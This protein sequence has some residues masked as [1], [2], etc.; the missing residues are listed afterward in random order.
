LNKLRIYCIFFFFAAKTVFP[1]EYSYKNFSVG[2]GLPQSQVV[3][4][5]QDRIGYLWFGTQSGGVARF[6]GKTFVTFNGKK[7]LP[8]N[9]VQSVY[10]DKKGNYWFATEEGLSNFD[11]IS[12]RNYGQS[13]GITRVNKVLGDKDGN[14]WFGDYNKGLFKFDGKK[15]TNYT[16][17]EG[18]ISNNIRNVYLT[19][20][21]RLLISTNAG[22]SIY[23]HNKFYNYNKS[24]GLLS[25]RTRS[26]IEDKDK[27]IW[28]AHRGGITIIDTK[29]QNRILTEKDGLPFN[30]ILNLFEDS[31]GGIW[32]CGVGGLCRFDGKKFNIVKTSDDA[33]NKR[34]YEVIEDKE[35][36]IWA[37]TDTKGA[38]RLIRTNFS[39]YSEKDGLANNNVWEICEDK[40]GIL[41]FATDRG[42]SRFDGEKFRTYNII[43]NASEDVNFCIYMDS[44]N[45]LWAGNNS[46]LARF[47]GS[48]FVL[49]PDP[50]KAFK[51]KAVLDILDDGQGN[52]WCGTFS[53]IVKYDGRKFT[54]FPLEDSL[55]V[56][57]YEVYQDHEGRI[58]IGTEYNGV[59]ICNGKQFTKFR[60]KGFEKDKKIWNITQ[61]KQNIFWFGLTENG[62]I[63]YNHETKEHIL[64]TSEDGLIDDNILSLGVDKNDMLWI[65]TNTGISRLDTRKFNNSGKIAIQNFGKEEG[66]RSIECNQN[67]QFIDSKN[68][69]WLGTID[70]VSRYA[71]SYEE[72]RNEVPPSI[73]ILGLKLFHESFDAGKYSDGID[74]LTGLPVNLRLDHDQNNIS[75]EFRGLSYKN[76]EKVK[77]KYRLLGSEGRWSPETRINTVSYP[78]LPP[79]K[80]TFQVIACNNEG[81]WNL[82]PA[83]FSFELVAPF[84]KRWW[85]YF[86]IIIIAGSG[87]FVFVKFRVYKLEQQKYYLENVIEER[88]Q[89]LKE[90]KEKVEDIN[91]EL[92]QINF[93]L[94]KIN[95]EL[96][97]SNK[98]LEKLSI[99]ARE[100]DNSIYIF[101]AN[102][103][104]EW[105]NTGAAKMIGYTLEQIIAER[106]TSIAQVSS[107]PEIE[108]AVKQAVVERRS[109]SYEVV[110]TN[111][112][113]RRYW[114]SCTLTPIFGKDD[115]LKNLVV[116]ETDIS[117]RRRVEEELKEAHDALEKRVVERTAELL[118]SNRLLKQQINIREWT[119]KELIKAKDKAEQADRL[120]SAFLAQMSHEI[121]TPLNVIL[122]YTSL[123]KEEL[124]EQLDDILKSVFFGINNAGRRLIR[125]I[126]LILNMSALQSGTHDIEIRNFSLNG[127][128]ESLITEFK[129]II[130]GKSIKLV[131]HNMIGE[132]WICADEYSIN[133]VFQNLIDNA[134]KFTPAG[135]I[136]ITLYT[137]NTGTV[138]VDVKDEGIGISEEYLPDLFKPFMQEEVGY[139][140]KFEGN[141]LG[142]ALVKKYIDMNNAEIKVESKK[143]KGTKFTVRFGK[144]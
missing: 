58:W 31:K 42:I 125:T 15:F 20:D 102:G 53:G 13:Y 117:H 89:Q 25:D 54:H 17:K 57:V 9:T 78:N 65:G 111:R 52:I 69:I 129:S 98:E 35:G 116:I 135:Q 11:G 120:K 72:D 90:E 47:D 91:H 137:D 46:G 2:D 29:G 75:F 22:F 68:N 61:D 77:Y 100:T 51:D 84:W 94:A 43:P 33:H 70:G 62:L 127:A 76:S 134:I 85:F 109:V 82:K 23:A 59:Y 45:T 105:L 50:D 119:E 3:T 144:Q 136:D 139:T 12:F 132:A 143:G 4:C 37:A 63:R 74:R 6:D 93:E 131:F 48:R 30:Q 10:Q 79:G 128:L 64:I 73:I 114:G 49:I 138:C 124:S 126:D 18:L 123:L 133:Q 112:D 110:N 55:I 40:D 113:G 38:C 122:S 44:R 66:F 14:I 106:G 141:G 80:Y 27:N 34:V 92:G 103:E 39:E 95:K 140:R 99:V 28:L 67:S 8:N 104:L 86:I 26:A 130:N 41:W 36:N 108:Q 107:Y 115:E 88:T 16:V 24:D 1:Q 83:V 7:G 19:R 60:I 101:D 87:I 97:V 118:E 121:R 142:L 5:Y 21:N 96:E 56:T 32:I 81:V 71:S